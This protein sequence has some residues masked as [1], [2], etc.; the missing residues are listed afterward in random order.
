MPKITLTTEINATP[1]ICFDFARSIDLHQISTA[2]TNEKAIA[3]RTSGLINLGETVTWEAIHFGIKQ[4]LTSK[5]TSFNRP[6]SFVGEQIK[7]VFKSIYHEH[8]FI[9]QDN[10]V[11]MIDIFEYESPFG[12]FGRIFNRLVLTNY[13][14]K[15]LV[16]RN[17]IIKAY[18][19]D[20]ATHGLLARS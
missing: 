4:K 13:L 19:E 11:L 18:A 7:G 8:T 12:I 20:P 17:Q 2:K 1:E 5:I 6:D 9:Q 15:L 14:K 10:A 16:T 3:G